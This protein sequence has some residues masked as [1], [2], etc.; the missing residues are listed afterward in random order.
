MN[1]C[2]LSLLVALGALAGATAAEPPRTIRYEEYQD[3]VHGVWL[4]K[5]IGVLLGEPTEFALQWSKPGEPHR[6]LFQGQDIS[7]VRDWIRGAP[8][9]AHDQDDLYI[10]LISLEALERYGIQVTGAQIAE[11]WLA[12]NPGVACANAAALNN[13]RYR[14]LPPLSGHPAFS[15]NITDIDAQ[16]DVDVWGMITPGMP[17]TCWE[18]TDRAARITNYGE[19]VYAA[20][21]I[22]SLISEGFFEK[23]ISRL[24]DRARCNVPAR[25]QYAQ[26]IDD[27]RRWHREFPDWRDARQ[28]LAAKYESLGGIHAVLNSGAVLLGLLYGEGDFDRSLFISM[29]CGWDSDCNPSTVGGILGA[30][31][32]ATGIPERWQA[33]LKDIYRGGTVKAYAPEIAISELGR[34][35]ARI[36]ERLVVASGGAVR[37]KGSDRV[38]LIPAQRPVHPPLDPLDAEYVRSVRAR[39]AAAAARDLQAGPN[40]QE[41]ACRRLQRV[42]QEDRSLLTSDVLNRAA[43]LAA[44][45]N[46]RVVAQAALLLGEAGDPRASESLLRVAASPDFAVEDRVRAVG[47]LAPSAGGPAG[48]RLAAI[49]L[50]EPDPAGPVGAAV[51][52]A[53]VK[54]PE[55]ALLE[56][57]SHVEKQPDSVRARLQ[58][59]LNDLGA[60]PSPRV[61]ASLEKLVAIRFAEWNPD[62]TVKFLGPDMSPGLRAE[63][64]GRANVLCT[65]PLDQNTAAVLEHEVTLPAGQTHR[66]EVT[67]AAHDYR[68]A[69]WELRV[70]VDQERIGTRTIGPVEGKAQWQT[71]TFDLSAYAGKTVRLRLE[72][73]PNG[74]AWEAGYWSTLRL[75]S[76]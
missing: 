38:L 8:D 22:A 14:I 39:V 35:T 73:A 36:G 19:G 13:F 51:L 50:A 41:T 40:R 17:R 4:G 21:F 23:D 47:L 43:V 33:P 16:I 2:L 44:G 52:A 63:Y 10:N 25:S 70:F 54:A 1:R 57:L 60:S 37:G 31:H 5:N 61:R 28:A 71:L 7:N 45:R 69:D 58:R 62:W 9:G 24:I 3:K 56:A 32:G 42:A 12:N 65:H 72:N 30:V 66:L 27:V 11:R 6:I 55:S 53:L 48:E 26:M 29:L 20:V 68:D 64:L 15:R 46:H 74:W 18:Y 59:T 76:E 34:R 75:I 49:F 67:V